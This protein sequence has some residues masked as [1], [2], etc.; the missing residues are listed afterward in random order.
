VK[1]KILSDKDIQHGWKI[2]DAKDQILGRLSTK[3]AMI[4][5]GK[6][7][8]TFSPHQDGGDFVIVINADKIKVTGRKAEAKSYFAHSFYPGGVKI[9]TYKTAMEKKP[10]FVVRHAIRG[11]IKATGPLGRKIYKKLFVYAGPDHPHAAQKP[12]T[13]TL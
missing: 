9:T 4:L 10:T 12:E 13:I 7:K 5:S 2:I 1:T 11:M 6:T 3:V 8:P